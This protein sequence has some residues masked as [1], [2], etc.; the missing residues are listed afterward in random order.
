M[1]DTWEDLELTGVAQSMSGKV[2]AFLSTVAEVASG[3]APDSEIPL[4]LLATSDILAA[5]ARLGAA[6]DVVPQERFEPDVGPEIDV[7]PL[8]EGL[9]RQLDGLDEYAEVVDPLYGVEVGSSSVSGDIALVADALAKGLQHH[10]AGRRREAMWWWQFSY[11][12]VWGE[13]AAAA[14][15]VLQLILAHLRLDVDDDVAAEA[16]YD[17][18]HSS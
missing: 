5:G 9:A 14:V 18:L 3:G 13:R 4:L 6:A 16:E 15:R 1:A 10:D 11:V 2:R 8:R 7:D 12:S 17:A